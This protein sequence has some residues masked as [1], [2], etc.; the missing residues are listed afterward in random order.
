MSKER[1]NKVIFWTTAIDNL[2]RNIGNIGGIAIQMNYWSKEFVANNW[3]V[4]SLSQNS[5][6]VFN[7]IKFLKLPQIRYVGI[8]IE[9]FLSLY[10]ILT[11]RPKILI[12]RGAARNISYLSLWCK[13]TKTK[14]VFFGASNSDFIPGEEILPSNKDKKLYRNGLKRINY[15]VAQN[16]EQKELLLKNYGNKKC[17]IIPN[18]WPSNNNNQQKKEIDYLWVGNFRGL[19]RPEWFIRLAEENPQYKFVMIGGPSDKALYDECRKKAENISNLS[20]LGGK[21]FDEVNNYFANA[22]CFVCTSTMEGFPNT[23]LQAW[24]NCIPVLSTFT[25]SG[26]VEKHNLGTVVNDYDEMNRGL[27]IILEEDNYKQKQQAI[28]LYFNDAHCPT[29]M[30]NKL[31]DMLDLA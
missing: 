24:S 18:I 14:F 20:F 25:P 9:I 27:H 31:M 22:R 7:D 4:Y 12:I 1:K 23:F 29:N 21:T 3:D 2:Y 10:Y 8:L 28:E 6:R 26:L 19:K 17:I 15:V 5:R 16:N 11:I 30:Y 13:L